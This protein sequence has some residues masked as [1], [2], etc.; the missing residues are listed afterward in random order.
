MAEF[1]GVIVK[2]AYYNSDVY[3]HQISRIK[4]EFLNAGLQISVF[5]NKKAA[6]IGDA[7]DI[8]FAVF[9]DKDVNFARVLENSG[10]RVFNPSK[11]ITDT[12]DKI[13]TAFIMD[14]SGVKFPKTIPAPLQYEYRID[15]TFLREVAEKLTFPLI[16]KKAVGSQGTGV[17]LARDFA[18]L[19]SI[20]SEIGDEKKLYQKFVRPAGKSIRT[21][22]IGGEIVASMLLVNGKDFRSNAYFGGVA[23][24]IALGEEYADAARKLGKIFGLDYCGIDFFAKQEEPTVIEINSNA[25]FRDLERVTGINIAKTYVEY[26]LRIMR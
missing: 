11:A 2:N 23:E 21:L 10:V 7:F 3:L 13:R 24:K 25:F 14:K 22:V 6:G 12:D 20:D 1:R 26:I 16:V 17:Y 5:E 8:D 9:L 4:E 19:S 15:E 18:E